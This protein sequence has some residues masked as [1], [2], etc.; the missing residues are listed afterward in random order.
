MS[1][2][3]EAGKADLAS[4]S[5]PMFCHRCATR[6][7]ERRPPGDER[8]R[9]VC[10]ECHLVAYENPKIVVGCVPVSR[11]GRRVLL[12]KRAISPVGTWT[13]PAGFLEVGENAEMGAM[14]EAWEEAR[15]E[16]DMEPTTLLAVYNILPAKQVQLLYRSIVLNEDSIAP[17]IESQE[18]HMFAWED[19]PWDKLAFPTV[20]WALEYSYQ[21][22]NAIILVPQLKNR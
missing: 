17:G 3:S 16:L 1:T 20:K 5:K 14:R 9:N 13:V 18:V 2:L 12:A 22:R 11:D 8:V 21:H 19:I 15:A 4:L 7:E 10:P 6:M